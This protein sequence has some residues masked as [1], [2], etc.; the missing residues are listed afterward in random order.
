MNNFTELMERKIL[1]LAMKIEGNDYLS[2]IKDGFIRIMPFLIIGSFFLLIANLPIPGYNEFIIRCFGEKFIGRL[3]YVLDATYS[4]MAL[5]VV[6]STSVSLAKRWQLNE[7]S[8]ALISLVSFLIV[9][10]FR[11]PVENGV[12]SDVIPVSALGAQG[13]FLSLIVTIIAVRLY[14]LFNHPRLTIQMPSSVPP[15]VANSFSSLIPSF[16]IVVLFWLARLVFE[17]TPFGTAQEMIFKVL[18]APM[19]ELGNTLPSQMVAEFFVSFFWFFG[20]HGDSIVTAI[21]GPIWRSLTL[22]NMQA[23]KQGLPPVNII[24]QQFRDVFLICGGTGFTLAMLLV[25]LFRAKSKRMR[26]IAKLA[27]PAAIFNINEP[28]IFG[29]PIALNPVLFIPFIIVPVVL[30]VITYSAM[31]FG[32]LPLTSGL[33]IPWT[34]PIFI[35]GFLICGWKG[36]LFQA[37]NLAVAMTIYYP[38]VMTLDKQYLREENAVDDP[39]TAVQPLATE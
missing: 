36:M 2:A 17:I 34:T 37:I 6:V 9:T 3:N 22:E 20:L 11:A 31:S 39:L 30:C 32:L 5:L 10:P 14:R 16:M 38:F 7:I 19:M 12:V 1:P 8:C 28:I 21:M 33:E 27:S 24:T 13:L 23:M 25:M 18:Q 26:E 15:A 4:I 29:V 35:S